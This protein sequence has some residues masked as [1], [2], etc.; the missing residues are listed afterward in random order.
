MELNATP[1]FPAVKISAVNS[2]Y[3]ATGKRFMMHENEMHSE[4]KDSKPSDRSDQEDMEEDKEMED[5]KM[6]KYIATCTK[7]NQDPR[8]RK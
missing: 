7:T 2:V 5:N 6:S 1:V 4:G 8:N 3:N